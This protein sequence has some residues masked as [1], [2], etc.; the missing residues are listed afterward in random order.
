MIQKHR[1]WS[2]Y[3][4]CVTAIWGSSFVVL[5]NAVEHNNP[6][7]FVFFRFALAVLCLG[8]L[9]FRRIKASLSFNLVRDGSILGFFCGIGFVLQTLAIGA[10]LPSH[11]AFLTGISVVLVPIFSNLLG[12]KTHRYAYV[13]IGCACLGLFV[14]AYEPGTWSLRFGDLLAFL[15]ALFYA[16]QIILTSTYARRHDIF[17]LTFMQCLV[18][19]AIGLLSFGVFGGGPFNFKDYHLWG[20]LA[21][22]SCVYTVIAYLVM[23]RAQTYLSPWQAGLIFLTEPLFAVFFS[24]LLGV[25]SLQSQM[26]IGGALILA[27]MMIA[28]FKINQ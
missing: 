19:A 9:F 23:N 16:W 5:K 11:V 1:I 13:A 2:F 28:E 26:L 22:S 15:C 8:V 6:Y 21:F 17:A 27:G 3:L 10:T 14:L 7:L 18:T 20:V 25:E 24:V 4:L 12:Q